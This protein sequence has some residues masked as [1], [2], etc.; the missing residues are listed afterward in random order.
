MRSIPFAFSAPRRR[1][2]LGGIRQS[3]VRYL[4]RF[5]G[6]S[7]DRNHDLANAGLG[8]KAVI[9]HAIKALS[10]DATWRSIFQPA[11]TG[12]TAVNLRSTGGRQPLDGSDFRSHKAAFSD[13]GQSTSR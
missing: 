7:A 13:P 6:Q 4:G 5:S 2:E 10:Q 12:S 1:T 3:R 8:E 11:S 9:D